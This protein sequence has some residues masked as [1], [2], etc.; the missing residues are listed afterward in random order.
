MRSK[1][2]LYN[3]TTNL[4]LQ[5]IVIVYGF[6]VPK[7][8]ITNYGSNV[9][10][11][12]TSITQF[13]AYITLL[14]SG[15][16]PVV[17]SLLYKPIA[18]K[19]KKEIENILKSTEKFFRN[20]AKIFIIY[21]IA[22]AFV[23][24]AL[25]NSEFDCL[26]SVSLIVIISIS[27]FAEYYF[28]LTYK[29]YL[30]SEQKTYIVSLIQI[31]SYIIC[32]ISI[33]IC[34]KLNTSI[35]ILKLVAGFTF[36]LRPLLQNYYVKK[37]FKID[38]TNANKDYKIKNKWDG[39][40]QHIASVIHSNTD[41]ALL[42]IFST[43]SEVSVYSV[44]SMVVLGIKKLVYIFNS[45]IEEMFGDMIARKESV[46]LNNK[47][48]TY[49]TLFFTI[50][51]IV[52]SS[53]LILI[54]PFISIYTKNVTDANYIRYLFG[55]LIV[56]SE[57]I[58]VIRNPYISLTYAAGHFKETRIGAWVECLSNI[59]VSIILLWK[60]GIVGVAIGTIVAMLIRTIEFLYH[61]NKYVLNRPIWK[62]L[63]KVFLI[64][65]ETLLIVF[66]CKYLPFTENISY[67]NWLI[68]GLMV[69][70]VSCIITL[71]IN[72]ILFKNEFKDAF[73]VLLNVFKKKTKNIIK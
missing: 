54:V 55:Y 64:I 42:T 13:L 63:K 66:V 27:T 17:K 37:K 3:I 61:S 71:T 52:F 69:F 31:V 30:Q 49:E 41:I 18:K 56:I 39:L 65:I 26:F 58:C 22:L 28:G 15:F 6:V 62:S 59:I 51:A 10:G 33:V 32:I 35:H 43:L 34:A 23:Y 21:I 44:Y 19:N 72:L 60:Y 7:I 24:P 25:I 4:V 16:S 68:N 5:I 67:F 38:L 48:D 45:G 40:A 1:K 57:Y 2:T 53:T 70:G 36:V 73:N 9:N 14:E 20:I 46:N 47:F 29:L 11:L 12:I 8:I 50:T